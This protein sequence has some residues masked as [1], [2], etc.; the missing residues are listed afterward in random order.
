[1]TFSSIPSDPNKDHMGPFT[2]PCV[3]FS[4]YFLLSLSLLK[5]HPVAVV[6][7]I[8]G[9]VVCLWGGYEIGTH[10]LDWISCR[11]EQRLYEEYVRHYETNE[12]EGLLSTEKSDDDDDDDDDKPLSESSSYLRRRR[13]NVRFPPFKNRCER[14]V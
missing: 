12:K 2:I 5:M 3:F 13:T 7:I 11:R 8:V 1:M 9:G 6:G 4:H 10:L 14:G